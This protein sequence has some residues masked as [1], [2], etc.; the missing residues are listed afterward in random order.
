MLSFYMSIK[1]GIGQI[2]ETTGTADKLSSLFIFSSF[3][4]FLLFLVAVFLGNV[5]IVFYL[6]VVKHV[7]FLL[8]LDG[9]NYFFV[10]N[11]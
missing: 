2:S 1:G 9:S 11:L 7:H 10:V 6:V 8:T 5:F 4:D 3:S